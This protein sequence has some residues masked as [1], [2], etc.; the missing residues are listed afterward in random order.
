LKLAAWVSGQAA[1]LVG[2]ILSQF[3]D[4][5]EARSRNHEFLQ[6]PTGDGE[7]GTAAK[8]LRIS[9]VRV[10]SAGGGGR[11]KDGEDSEQSMHVGIFHSV[12]NSREIRDLV[13]ERL[14][15][16][17]AAGLGDPDDHKD[18]EAKQNK[19]AAVSSSDTLAAAKEVLEAARDLRAASISGSC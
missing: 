10:Q 17:R 7:P 3:S 6:C 15:K 16:F 5:D 14:R 13:L 1:T 19:A 9:D 18:A 4:R 2:I 8:L 11:K 12:D